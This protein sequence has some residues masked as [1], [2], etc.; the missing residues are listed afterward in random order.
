MN[1]YTHPDPEGDWFCQICGLTRDVHIRPEE[2]CPTTQERGL[3]SEITRLCI[4]LAEARESEAEEQEYI[5]AL[6]AELGRCQ[7][8]LD[9]RCTSDPSK[10]GC[11]D[12]LMMVSKEIEKQLSSLAATQCV[13]PIAH[14]HGGMAC[15]EVAKEREKRKALE[16][17]AARLDWL[18]A[19]G[20]GVTWFGPMNWSGYGPGPGVNEVAEDTDL[21]SAIDAAMEASDE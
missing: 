17:D 10:V 21:R 16:K 8:V 15:G 18:D 9:M 4:E 11:E 13:A 19:H 20:D 2:R 6:R 14:P 7:E 3:V 1:T 12:T 5:E